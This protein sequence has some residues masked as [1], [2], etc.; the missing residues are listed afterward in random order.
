VQDIAEILYYSTR[1]T[2][3]DGLVVHGEVWQG[4]RARYATQI[5]AEVWTWVM[6]YLL[7]GVPIAKIISM[8]IERALQLKSECIIT[9]CNRFLWEWNIQNIA[10][11]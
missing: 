5:S 2:K 10:L 11:I 7:V 8:H 4:D 9:D 6:N 3:N 1:H